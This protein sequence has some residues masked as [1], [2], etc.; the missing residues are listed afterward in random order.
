[1]LQAYMYSN[2]RDINPTHNESYTLSIY[3]IQK[4]WHSYPASKQEKLAQCCVDYGPTSPIINTTLGQRFL[5]TKSHGARL[6]GRRL[7]IV[8][9]CGENMAEGEGGY[10]GVT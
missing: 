9:L 6:P 7:I 5:N 10:V 1:M 3:L 2:T 4:I 8:G